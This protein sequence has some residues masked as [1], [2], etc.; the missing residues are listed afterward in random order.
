MSGYISA[1]HMCH[2]VL[3]DDVNLE[4]R[5]RQVALDDDSRVNLEAR[6]HHAKGL[7]C[8]GGSGK[9]HWDA[10]VQLVQAVQQRE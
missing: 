6:L 7:G 2:V 10:R 9:G 1:M 3:V 5:T 8:R 4:V